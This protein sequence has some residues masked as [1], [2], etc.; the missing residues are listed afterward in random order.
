MK[1]LKLL[2]DLVEFATIIVCSLALV[3]DALC[4]MNLPMPMRLLMI[5]A[6]ILGASELREL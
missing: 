3:V 4:G 1:L 5:A 6:I 2:S